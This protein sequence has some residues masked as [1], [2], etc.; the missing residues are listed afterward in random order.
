MLFISYKLLLKLVI[1]I[2]N[3]ATKIAVFDNDIIINLNVVDD[4]LY[5]T[6]QVTFSDFPKISSSILSSV[7]KFDSSIIEL[8]ATKGKVI[9]LTHNTKIPFKNNYGTPETLGKDRIAIAS[10]AVMQHFGKNVLIIDIGTCVTYDFIN[11]KGEYIGGSISLGLIMRFKAL[12]NYTHSLPLEILP[13]YNAEVNL[14]GNSTSTS[15][16]SGVIIGLQSEIENIINQYESLFTPLKIIISGGDYKYF[17]KLAKSNI[18]ASPNIV[19]HGLK[20]ILDFNE[21]D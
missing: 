19:V 4:N 9:E 15:I 5:D 8:L 11:E 12:H 7:S 3:T 6:I 18:F 14:I 20:K 2:G 17:E 21:K 10:A 16:L 1:D 13:D